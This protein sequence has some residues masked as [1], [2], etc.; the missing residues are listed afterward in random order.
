[1]RV[2]WIAD[3]QNRQYFLN[4]LPVV[5]FPLQPHLITPSPKEIAPSIS[6]AFVS[7]SSQSKQE[8]RHQRVS[9]DGPQTSITSIPKSL[10]EMQILRPNPDLLNQKS[11]G[12]GPT[13]CL[14]KFSRWFWCMS[15]MVWQPCPLWLKKHLTVNLFVFPGMDGIVPPQ[16]SLCWITNPQCDS[17][18]R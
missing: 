17:L 7:N 4:I 6:G 2:N 15:D 11:W 3:K 9:Q 8:R 14:N 18:W 5:Y 13:M 10:L 16:N 1:M 12:W